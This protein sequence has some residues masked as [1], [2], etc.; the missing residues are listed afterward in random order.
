MFY[1]YKYAYSFAYIFDSTGK[2]IPITYPV[3]IRE[4][5]RSDEK[6]YYL[7][8]PESFR[9]PEVIKI[10]K[11]IEELQENGGKKR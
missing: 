11:R 4:P 9:T 5:V 1:I 2:A 7:E 6:I 10:N 3:T 8:I